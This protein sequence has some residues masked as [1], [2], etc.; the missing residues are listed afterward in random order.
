MEEKLKK[1]AEEKARQEEETRKKE[2][3]EK[4]EADRQK[5]L[6]MAQEIEKKSKDKKETK[7]AVA[8][9]FEPGSWA[10]QVGL[11][12]GVPFWIQHLLASFAS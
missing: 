6:K 1:E 3:E 8:K 5:L 11:V 10:A 9:M 12:T 7:E 2:A 4:A